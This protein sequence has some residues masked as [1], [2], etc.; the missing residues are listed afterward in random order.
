MESL[1][2][3]LETYSDID[4]KK[5]GVY[6]YAESPNFEILL[7]AYSVDNG[8]VQVIDLAQGEDIPTEILAALTDE[9]ITKWAYNASFE[10]ICLSVWLRRNHPAYFQSYSILEDTVGDYLDPSACPA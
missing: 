1:S 4:L 7:F 5:C 2:I 3:D 9:T 10:R 8:P 6:K